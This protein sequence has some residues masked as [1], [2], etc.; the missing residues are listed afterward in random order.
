MK[1][2]NGTP[3]FIIENDL[4]KRLDNLGY[5]KRTDINSLDKVER[6]LKYHLERLN[7]DELNNIELPQEVFNN[8][9]INEIKN[10]SIFK[11]ARNFRDL[12]RIPKN[13]NKS[14]WR[15]KCY[16]SINFENNIFEYSHQIIQ[17]ERFRNRTD[18]TI[19][20]NGIPIVQIELKKQGVDI[21]EA[22]NQV[23][24]Y[25]KESLDKSVFKILQL[26]VISNN[27][28]T[29]YFSNNKKIDKESCFNWSNHDNEILC[30]LGEFSE[31][32][33]NKETL[34]KLLTDYTVLKIKEEITMVLRPYQFFAVE[35]VLKH[36]NNTNKLNYQIDDLDERALKL[37]AYI[38]HATGSG[39]T[40]TSFKVSQ[41]LPKKEN[42]EKVIFLVDRIDLNKQTVDEFKAYL[43]ENSDDLEETKNS[44][45]LSQQLKDSTNNKIPIVTTIQKMIHVLKNNKY[46]FANC[47]KEL[48][49]KN[50]VF[51][52]DE[53]HRT[54]FGEMHK[55]LRRTF[56]KSRLIGFTG[57]PIFAKNAKNTMTTKEIFGQLLHK[58]MM[59]NAI[60]DKNVLK[61]NIDYIKGPKS[62]LDV[63]K[64]IEVEG[65]DTETFFLSDLYMDKVVDY[66][67]DI[68]QVKTY[69]KDFK[70]MLVCENIKA[71]IKYYWKFREKYP[72]LKVATVFSKVDNEPIDSIVDYES[73]DDI[74]FPKSEQAKII[75]DYNKV[76]NTNFNELDFKNYSRHVQGEVSNRYGSINLVIVVRMLTTGFNAKFLNTVYLDRSLKEYELIQTISRANRVANIEKKYAN[77]VSFRTFKKDVD[78]AMSLY[79]NNESPDMLFLKDDLNDFIFQINKEIQ[80]V[81]DRWGDPKTLLDN[82]SE[83]ERKDFVIHMKTINK[84][85]NVAKTFIKFDMNMLLIDRDELNRWRDILK[86]IKNSVENNPKKES[87]LNDIDF[88]LEIFKTDEI[89]VDYILANL[90]KLRNSTDIET[91]SYEISKVIDDIKKRGLKS[92][93]KLLEEFILKWKAKMMSDE[94]NDWKHRHIGE[95]Y[96]DYRMQNIQNKIE[97]FAQENNLNIEM[98]KETFS[99]MGFEKKDLDSYNDALRKIIDYSN[100]LNFM[101]KENMIEKI[102]KFYLNI[103]NNDYI[104]NLE[105]L[106]Y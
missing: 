10:N 72:D 12:I 95:I 37:N 18:V 35:S 19:F 51:V 88:E 98:L 80:S 66:I 26:F 105:D 75:E 84:L 38:W 76:Y 45:K 59:I 102:K 89:N 56:L 6:N 90:E 42:V 71:A 61:F 29:K 24:R 46:G 104:E 106:L 16:D 40:L 23:I 20:L 7:K 27:S 44:E 74:K 52:I 50:Y 3:E 81:K 48:E 63:G 14:Y 55:E 70:S 17:D 43:G 97:Y 11:N 67:Y 15:L 36:I 91:F 83:I 68:N 22:F 33:L 86:E 13:D 85:F 54:Q 62:K 78:H 99:K 1:Y 5:I 47:K 41:L 57:T 60:K 31:S 87:I 49:N 30:N 69:N 65:I 53:C 73:I 58:Y 92:K 21:F 39:K 9:V 32:F 101:E 82:G 94:E 93:A 100:K 8:Y 28:T 25:K 2:E 34:F 79:N 103:E 96:Q 64:D 4:M 77:V